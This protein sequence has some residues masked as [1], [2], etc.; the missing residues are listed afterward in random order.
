M[1][2]LTVGMMV[3][4]F[5][6]GVGAMSV[7]FLLGKAVLKLVFGLRSRRGCVLRG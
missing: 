1:K 5:A 7:L 6:F 4:T 2:T 3:A